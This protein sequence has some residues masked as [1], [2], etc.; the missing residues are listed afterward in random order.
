[1]NYT[2]NGFSDVYIDYNG[3][4]TTAQSPI[5]ISDSKSIPLRLRVDKSNSNPTITFSANN[6]ESA[7]F[8][9]NRTEGS[10]DSNVV[11]EGALL[12][13]GYNVHVSKI[14]IRND[15]LQGKVFD[16]AV[17]TVEYEVIN[18][19]DDFL[20]IHGS[21]I[22][23][24][25]N[26]GGMATDYTDNNTSTITMTLNSTIIENIGSSSI[27]MQGYG[28]VL[29]KVTLTPPVNVT[30]N[31]LEETVSL[32][33]ATNEAVLYVQKPANVTQ[34]TITDNE[35]LFGTVS[36]TFANANVND[37]G[38]GKTISNLPNYAATIPVKLEITQVVDIKNYTIV[39]AGN[40]GSSDNVTINLLSTWSGSHSLGNWEGFWGSARKLPVGSTVQITFADYDNNCS[41]ELH[42][43]N[44]STDIRLRG[45]ST[46]EVNDGKPDDYISTSYLTNGVFT[47][48]VATD[49]SVMIRDNGILKYL[50]DA[51]L[52]GL[53]INGGNG[54]SVTQVSVT[55][56]SGEIT[57]TE[58][59]Y[60]FEDGGVIL[61]SWNNLETNN[62]YDEVLKSNVLKLTVKIENGQ[63]FAQLGI[64]GNYT[65]SYTLSLRYRIG[66]AEASDREMNL[67]FQE[68]KS[69]G[70]EER[71][72]YSYTNISTSENTFNQQITLSG[73]VEQFVIQFANVKEN[74]IFYIDDLKLVKN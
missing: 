3:W 5:T 55:L 71:A 74:D 17:L 38:N 21:G 30:F 54:L 50:T 24:W 72:T 32:D 18:D 67:V 12:F 8:T 40:D 51:V 65:G 46:T 62:V 49:G 47:F 64:T 58:F 44:S 68:G 25:A 2:K 45:F 6:V 70:Y 63:A 43:Y 34:L 11:W 56:G 31:V 26:I 22:S 4:Y 48:T 36:T 10:T 52:D 60:N 42:T 69:E 9:V 7:T 73:N 41:F 20:S 23:N 53:Q 1:M 14:D 37:N 59:T 66:T 35:N 28:R 39:V 33:L 13:Q 61:D 19:N 16:G 15:L 57:P 27:N 29:K